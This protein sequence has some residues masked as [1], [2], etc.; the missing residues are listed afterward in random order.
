MLYARWLPITMGGSANWA[1][2]SDGSWRSGAVSDEQ[3]SS[4]QATVKGPGTV[5]FHWNV[6][7]EDPSPSRRKRGRYTY[8]DAL[9]WMVDGIQQAKITGV[10]GGWAVVS[11]RIEGTGPHVIKWL[12]DKDS[13]LSEG[14]DCGWIRNVWWSGSVQ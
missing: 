8:A 6:S 9:C 4:L 11:L 14:S 2:Q 7:C 3:S 5:T 1:L 13:S 10:S 12:Y